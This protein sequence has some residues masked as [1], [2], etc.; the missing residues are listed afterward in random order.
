MCRHFDDLDA[1]LEFD[2]LD[3]FGRV[4]FHEQTIEPFGFG[5]VPNLLGRVRPIERLIGILPCA[6]NG[7]HELA[8]LRRAWAILIGLT[9]MAIT[10]TYHGDSRSHS[11]TCQRAPLSHC[12][13]SVLCQA[14][15]SDAAGA[16]KVLLADVRGNLMSAAE[17][18]TPPASNSR[19]LIERA[20]PLA[21][22][23]LALVTN[24]V[25]IGFLGYWVGRLV[26]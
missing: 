14:S 16:L 3:D 9:V 17:Q 15:H 1:V 24:A 21:G 23:G 6:I 11:L 8:G 20:W 26:L 12:V 13:T 18:V 19:S 22:L 7:E 2:A 4:A 5:N 10:R 25:W